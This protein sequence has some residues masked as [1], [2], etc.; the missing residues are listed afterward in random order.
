M[1]ITIDPTLPDGET[2]FADC[3]ARRDS[4]EGRAQWLGV[5][6][7]FVIPTPDRGM[8]VQELLRIQRALT[9][10]EQYLDKLEGQIEAAVARSSQPSARNRDGS[11]TSLVTMCALAFILSSHTSSHARA[12]VNRARPTAS[13]GMTMAAFIAPPMRM[14]PRAQVVAPIRVP[15]AAPVVAAPVPAVP[16]PAPV[17]PTEAAAA[18]PTEAREQPRCLTRGPN[19]VEGECCVPT[20]R[21]FGA[22]ARRFQRD[23]NYAGHGHFVCGTHPAQT[24]QDGTL[25]V[26]TCNWCEPPSP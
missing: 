12:S 11:W 21:Q 14:V 25:D 26:R 19:L 9:K 2:L 7:E 6:E 13:T 1:R 3:S 20:R 8:S 10:F 24:N 22:E 15:A 4:A 5:E 17:A 23:P 18:E 16:P